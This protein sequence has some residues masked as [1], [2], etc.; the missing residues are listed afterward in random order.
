M[1][2]IIFILTFLFSLNAFSIVGGRTFNSEGSG[3]HQVKFIRNDE[4]DGVCSGVIIGD[5]TLL[6]SAHC[7]ETL[8]HGDINLLSLN[9]HNYRIETFWIPLEYFKFN[10]ERIRNQKIYNQ[11]CFNLVTVEDC[12][13]LFDNFNSSYRNTSIFDLGIVNLVESFPGGLGRL[14]ISYQIEQNP[15]ELVAFGASKFDEAEKLCT[16]YGEGAFSRTLSLEIEAFLDQESIFYVLGRDMLDKV[17]CPGDSGGTVLQN[18]WLV[19][20]ISGSLIKGG[21]VGTIITPLSRHEEFLRTF[22]K[23]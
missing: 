20:L 23:E 12:E 5:F 8:N 14:H 18:D 19:G 4:I 2:R 21:R 22:V 9:D 10:N 7:I 17:S 3:I 1:N 15:V 11:E 6:T 16:S 13:K